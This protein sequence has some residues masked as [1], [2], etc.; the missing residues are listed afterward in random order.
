MSTN[1][2]RFLTRKR[3]RQMRRLRF[4]LTNL[5]RSAGGLDH[6]RNERTAD[7]PV[8]TGL[9]PTGRP[10]RSTQPRLLNVEIG[11]ITRHDLQRFLGLRSIAALALQPSDA[12][13]KL[14]DT[15]LGFGNALGNSDESITVTNHSLPLCCGD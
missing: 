14:A 11:K 3:I 12:I 8:L 4:C 6:G 1:R 7:A 13:I 10:H 15:V 2:D 5:R 9:R